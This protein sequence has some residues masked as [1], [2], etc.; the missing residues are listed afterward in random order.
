MKVIFKNNVSGKLRADVNNSTTVLPVTD[1]FF[2]QLPTIVPGQEFFLVTLTDPNNLINQNE[3]CKV[4]SV[5]GGPGTYELTV[6]RN[7]GGG[8]SDAFSASTAVISMRLT[9][10]LLNDIFL[11]TDE[12]ALTSGE[13]IK[14]NADGTVASSVVGIEEKF[15]IVDVNG[16]S[17]FNVT[18]SDIT[19]LPY[20][21]QVYINGL[22][23][24]ESSDY[25]YTWDGVNTKVVFG[26]TLVA[27][28]RV[29]IK[30]YGAA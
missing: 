22:K 28:T 12:S 11:K 17:T 6:Q 18:G 20:I 8:G 7:Y 27:G 15:N 13:F 3:V 30:V 25:T 26:T 16:G 2:A 29:D 19:G 23:Q 10:K 24:D 5:S 4:T 1:A 21:V 9:A 14:V